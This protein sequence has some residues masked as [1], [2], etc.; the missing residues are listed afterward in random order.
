MK[1][2]SARKVQLALGKLLTEV[3]HLNTWSE[4]TFTQCASKAHVARTEAI[5][6]YQ[7][8]VEMNLLKFDKQRQA[9]IANFDVVIWKDEDAKLGLIRE[10][11]EMFQIRL[12]KGPTKGPKK[13]AKEVEPKA[14]NMAEAALLLQAEINPLS[15]FSAQDLVDELRNRGYEVKASKVITTIEE[16]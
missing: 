1:Q 3:Y 6:F 5:R 13:S 2:S 8:L 15:Q 16:L 10:L 11:M 14:K 9:F 4:E 12:P 7:A